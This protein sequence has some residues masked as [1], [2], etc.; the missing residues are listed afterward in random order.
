M[1][2][3]QLWCEKYFMMITMSVCRIHYSIGMRTSKVNDLLWFYNM[4][5]S[6]KVG[7]V[8]RGWPVKTLERLLKENRHDNVCLLVLLLSLSA[9]L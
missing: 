6:G 3:E 8:S 7:R 9:L 5:L 2:A 4:G 1:Y